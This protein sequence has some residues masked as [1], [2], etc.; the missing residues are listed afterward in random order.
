MAET[1]SKV[2]ATVAETY[3]NVKAT[4]AETYSKLRLLWLKHTVR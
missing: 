3:R 1:H 4:V 2:K